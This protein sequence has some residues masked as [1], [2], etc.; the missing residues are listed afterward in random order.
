V[1]YNCP[2]GSALHCCQ[3][4]Q[5]HSTQ[6]ENGNKIFRL[7]PHSDSNNSLTWLSTAGS[8]GGLA[9]VCIMKRPQFK[10]SPRITTTHQESKHLNEP[11]N[12]SRHQ[13][14]PDPQKPHHKSRF[15]CLHTCTSCSGFHVIRNPSYSFQVLHHTRKA[16]SSV[17][18]V[19]Q[20]AAPK[21]RSA[22]LPLSCGCQAFCM[23]R[24]STRQQNEQG[25]QHSTALC[26]KKGM[27]QLP[28][29]ES[30]QPPFLTCHRWHDQG[31]AN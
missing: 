30:L 8:R 29:R 17:C 24:S 5:H 1:H 9:N 27:T 23:Q 18:S 25:S 2:A 16:S 11:Y 12:R 20:I 10:L 19:T 3:A 13:P 15:S 4:R 31:A 14:Q 7:L 28:G 22:L 6:R 21:H 26:K